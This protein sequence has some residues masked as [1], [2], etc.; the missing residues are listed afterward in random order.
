[1]LFSLSLLTLITLVDVTEGG[2]RSYFSNYFDEVATSSCTSLSVFYGLR[3]HIA[4]VKRAC[5]DNSQSCADV[6]ERAKSKHVTGKC[7]EI[8][9]YSLIFFEI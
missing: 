7:Q 8:I 4:A 5:N 9:T 1:M 3:G 6:C 2:L